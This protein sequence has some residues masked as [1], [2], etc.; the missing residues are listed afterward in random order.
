M[1]G[2]LPL[3]GV[4]VGISWFVRLPIPPIFRMCILVLFM[5]HMF[6]C[7]TKLWAFTCLYFRIRRARRMTRVVMTAQS[8]NAKHAITKLPNVRSLQGMALK[9]EIGNFTVACLM[10]QSTDP[11]DEEFCIGY[12]LNAAS[13]H[14]AIGMC[15]ETP[16]V[17]PE[18]NGD[19]PKIVA[20]R[21]AR[22]ARQEF[23][24]GHKLE[25]PLDCEHDL[26]KEL[27]DAYLPSFIP[28]PALQTAIEHWRSETE[29][30]SQPYN[31]VLHAK[32]MSTNLEA[33]NCLGELA[34]AKLDPPEKLLWMG[35]F[36]ELKHIA[37]YIERC[38]KED[39]NKRCGER[40]DWDD[41]EGGRRRR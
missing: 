30:T 8:A 15:M 40:G 4:R 19:L 6:W 33:Q 21:I 25:A 39:T 23:H 34:H 5:L 11:C 17:D 7:C 28:G 38:L 27:V 14:P 36:P 3:L 9:E 13:N 24:P 12:L 20:H 16:S 35:R 41:C 29:D 1:V 32:Y 26:L 22:L 2:T 10:L 31:I 37:D 18:C